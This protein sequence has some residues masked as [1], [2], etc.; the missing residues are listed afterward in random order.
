[1]RRGAIPS[2]W[3]TFDDDAFV[4]Y[5]NAN[6]KPRAARATLS[7][8]ASRPHPVWGENCLLIF[9]TGALEEYC[10]AEAF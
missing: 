5:Y 2:F 9:L 8:Y 1:M 4:A 3:A 7:N 10:Y 6:Q